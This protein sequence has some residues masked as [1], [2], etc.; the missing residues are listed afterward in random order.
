MVAAWCVPKRLW[1]VGP[2]RDDFQWCNQQACTYCQEEIETKEAA[3]LDEKWNHEHIKLTG[4]F[5]K[6]AKR[7]YPSE[8]NA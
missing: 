6:S 5:K 2:L 3:S 8:H 7:K 1:Q 4:K